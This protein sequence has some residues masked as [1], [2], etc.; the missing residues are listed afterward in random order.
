[1]YYHLQLNGETVNFIA[2]EI[3]DFAF[4]R[5]ATEYYEQ[6]RGVVLRN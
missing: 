2:F 1:M 6:K 3:N 4:S 5:K